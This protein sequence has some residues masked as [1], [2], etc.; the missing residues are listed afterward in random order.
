MKKFLSLFLAFFAWQCCN[1]QE[2]IPVYLD[3]L[4]DNYYLIHPS[5]AGAANCGKIRGTVRQQW[6]DQQNAPNLQTLNFN[7][8]VGENSGIGAII[9]NDQNGYHSQTG[10]YLS[11]AY[12]LKIGGIYNTLNQISF[13]TNVG[14]VQ[15][16]LDETE[17]D[18][19][20]FDPEIAG[21]VLSDSYFNV[22]IGM[23]YLV[24]EFYA[25]FTVKNVLFQNRGLYS[26]GF[27]SA[28]QRRYIASVGYVFA[29][30]ESSWQFEP[31]LL[32]QLTDLT[33]EQFMDFNGKAYYDLNDNNQL[34]LGLSYRQSFEGAEFD[35]GVGLQEQNLSLLSPIVG[36]KYKQFT[37]GYTYSYQ[38]GDIK[39]DNG[40]FH[41][42]TLGIDFLC[43]KE[44]WSCNC[45]AVNR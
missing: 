33:S 11:Y 4:T 32:Y 36:L 2:G 43:R 6:F 30:S 27:E 41:Q 29:P 23:S 18:S 42:I 16:R 5:M 9:F 22:D 26:E 25:H 35:N 20:I 45:P 13:G 38:F 15:S 17:F 3:Y 7:T 21:V 19:R 37:F 28:N 39:F 12:H 24:K 34:F 10:G 44:R 1:A 8:A 40:G 14:M 31:S